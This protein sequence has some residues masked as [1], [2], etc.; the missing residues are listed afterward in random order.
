LAEQNQN[1]ATMIEKKTLQQVSDYIS[2]GLTLS[3]L[4]FNMD[5]NL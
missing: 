5:K 1:L 4:T 3:K 2:Q